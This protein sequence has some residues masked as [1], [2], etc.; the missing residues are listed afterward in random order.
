MMARSMA[1]MTA[2]VNVSTENP[3]TSLDVRRRSPAFITNAKSPKVAKFIGKVRSLIMGRI[4]VVMIPQTS[5]VINSAWYPS[6]I[7]P[8]IR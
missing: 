6:T 8:G 3:V 4:K 5:A 7:T 1:E 2:V